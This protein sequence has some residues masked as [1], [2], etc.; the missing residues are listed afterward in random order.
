MGRKQANLVL[1]KHSVGDHVGGPAEALEKYLLETRKS[2]GVISHP[3]NSDSHLKTVIKDFKSG[4]LISISEKP[5]KHQ[6]VYTFL[7]DLIATPRIQ[8]GT[9]VV[10]FNPWAVVL[11]KFKSL[12]KTFIIFWGVDFI[13][14]QKK[15][16]FRSSLYKTMEKF[17]FRFVDFQIENNIFALQERRRAIP[18]LNGREIPELVIPISHNFNA[19]QPIKKSEDRLRILYVGGLNSRNGGTFLAEIARELQ[20]QGKNFRLDVIGGGHSLTEIDILIRKYNLHEK[21]ILHGQIEDEW[22]PEI[23][24]E[25][26]FGLAPY[27]FGDDTFTKFADPGKLV[28][29]AAFGLVTLVSRVP[30]ITTE[31]EQHAS[32]FGMSEDKSAADWAAKL[33]QLHSD[34]DLLLTQRIKSRSYGESRKSHKIFEMLRSHDSLG[35]HFK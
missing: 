30:L 33:I 11:A 32:F 29:Y 35:H 14:K 6:G 31:Y 24:R 27:Q 3:L 8:E 1:I 17:A 18:G 21:V 19:D 10:C 16:S 5:R 20:N 4:Q 12:G 15:I 2:F 26:S 28:F 9:T 13:P 7:F 22:I 25:A 34:Q 23:A